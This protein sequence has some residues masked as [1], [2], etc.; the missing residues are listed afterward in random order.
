MEPGDV[1][2]QVVEAHAGD[3][4]GAVLVD[5][6]EGLHDVHMVGDGEVR[7]HGVSEALHLHVAAVVRADGHG[8]VNDV[9]DDIEDVPD[10]PLQLRLQ[11]VQLR[12]AGIVGLDGG[13]VG[14]DLLLNGGFLPLVGALFQLAVEGAVGLGEAVA[15]GLQLLHLGDGSPPLGVQGDDLVH[16]G[17]LFL[18]EL[19]ADVLLDDVR[20]FPDKL[21]IQHGFLLLFAD[22]SAFD[23]GFAP[24]GGCFT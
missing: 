18:L 19:L 6:V 12:A 7:Y 2:Q 4:A 17:E 16:Q 24:A 21:D 15:V 1:A 8:G 23:V 20:V 10:L 3:S 9:G 22:G 5:A 11:G 13:V 14:V